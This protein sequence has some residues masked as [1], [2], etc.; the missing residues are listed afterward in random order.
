LSLTPLAAP[1][2]FHT[3]EIPYVF[4][5]LQ[6]RDWPWRPEDRRMAELVSSYWVNFAKSGDPNGAGL[7][8]WPVYAG[9][10]GLVMRLAEQPVAGADPGLARYD[11]L[12]AYYFGKEQ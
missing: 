11:V 12:D 2:V 6:T 1:G 4:D 5:N 9:R 7:P 8:N 3:A 10:D